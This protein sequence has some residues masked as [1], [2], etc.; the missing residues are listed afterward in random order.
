MVD[1]VSRM[2]G[3][4]HQLD[5]HYSSLGEARRCVQY[6]TADKSGPFM[7][8][9]RTQ[10]LP[11]VWRHFKEDRERA[12]TVKRIEWELRFATRIPDPAAP[13]VQPMEGTSAPATSGRST[14]RTTRRAAPGGQD[15]QPPPPEP[16]EEL[17]A[18]SSHRSVGSNLEALEPL[19]GLTVWHQQ[20][21]D[22][23]VALTM[24][25][26]KDHY[27]LLVAWVSDTNPAKRSIDLEIQEKVAVQDLSGGQ[28]LALFLDGM[29]RHTPDDIMSR[30]TWNNMRRNGIGEPVM[31]FAQRYLSSARAVKALPD[32]IN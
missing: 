32:D 27:E 4:S 21:I 29:A 13:P 3:G 14:R 17:P 28:Q 18:E 30:A 31:A 1:L 11:K 22:R 7:D 24:P 26:D 15:T 5:L 8:W 6:V 16:D 20:Q 25:T 23:A 10:F 19:Y 9:Y 2:G 12:A